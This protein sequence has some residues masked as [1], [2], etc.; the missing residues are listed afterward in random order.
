MESLTGELHLGFNA[1]LEQLGLPPHASKQPMKA[2]ARIYFF[3][4]FSAHAEG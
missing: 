2:R 1:A 4:D 3:C